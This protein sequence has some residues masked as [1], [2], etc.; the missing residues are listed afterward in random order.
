VGT[1]PADELRL[2]A[3]DVQPGFRQVLRDLL[4]VQ[5]EADD[6]GIGLTA[7]TAGPNW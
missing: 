2:D 3:D 1:L 4:P 5:A 6:D 7:T